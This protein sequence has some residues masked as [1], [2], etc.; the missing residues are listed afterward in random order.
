MDE[1]SRK[2]MNKLSQKKANNFEYEEG[3]DIIREDLYN[4]YFQELLEDLRNKGYN[5]TSL[6]N[7]HNFA[8]FLIGIYLLPEKSINY[9]YP[10]IVLS[11]WFHE[12]KD[13]KYYFDFIIEHYNDYEAFLNKCETSIKKRKIRCPHYSA[14][15]FDTLK[16]IL[17]YFTTDPTL[18]FLKK[19]LGFLRERNYLTRNYFI[20][21]PDDWEVLR[22]LRYFPTK[23]I[24]DLQR[25]YQFVPGQPKAEALSL[26]YSKCQRS[27]FK[28][29][30]MKGV[31]STE[32]EYP[33]PIEE[34]E[35]LSTRLEKFMEL[36]VI[37][38]FIKKE[39]YDP[40]RINDVDICNILY[41]YSH[42]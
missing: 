4:K 6:S 40:N 13:L 10:Y 2:K 31:L 20:L 7:R 41:K 34:K 27:S 14:S 1:L 5:T 17:N 19:S 23:A 22:Q 18:D 9:F 35:F 3:Y 39:G 15:V 25:C 12:K 29:V 32:V 8:I 21:V 42:S 16:I 33:I 38:D 24:L 28:P 26:Y 11:E 37:Q 30:C 36:D